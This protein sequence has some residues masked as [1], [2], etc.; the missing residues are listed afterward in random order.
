[1][2][3]CLRQLL[4]DLVACL[5]SQSSPLSFCPLTL[6]PKT[7]SHLSH[8][9]D[10]DQGQPFIPRVSQIRNSV[11]GHLGRRPS[12]PG[13]RVTVEVLV[14]ENEVAPVRTGLEPLQ[15]AEHRPAAVSGTKKN[16]GHPA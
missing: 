10:N 1:M 13:S 5:G 2:P 8:D 16:V 3:L 14:K 4:F 6:V 15:V 7:L 11:C 9:I 12:R